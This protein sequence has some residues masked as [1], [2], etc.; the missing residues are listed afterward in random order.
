MANIWEWIFFHCFFVLI[1]LLHWIYLPVKKNG[2]SKSWLL[3]L[4]RRNKVRL[5]CF[6]AGKEG[7]EVRIIWGLRKTSPGPGR[8]W[9]PKDQEFLHPKS[10]KNK[11]WKWAHCELTV[12]SPM[13]W[14]VLTEERGQDSWLFPTSGRNVDWL[15]LTQLMPDVVSSW[16]QKPSCIRTTVFLP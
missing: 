16:E 11:V 5:T 15:D 8:G 7:K 4:E 13:K 10:L 14:I 9:G 1:L 3:P 12:F 2:Y 6:P